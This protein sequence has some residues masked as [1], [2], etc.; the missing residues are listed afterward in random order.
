MHP[1][2]YVYIHFKKD[3]L[4]PFYVGKGTKYRLHDKRQRNE[5]WNNIVNKHG[6]IASVYEYFEEEQ[7]AFNLEIKLI[8]DLKSKGF[9]LCNIDDGG[10]GAKEGNKNLLGHK[11]SEETKKKIGLAGLGRKHSEETKRKIAEANRRRVVTEETKLKIS[12]A[13]RKNNGETCI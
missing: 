13:K 10:R 5:W 1:K 6:F 8:A 4:E 12:N 11:H 9:N 2:H 7:E 3:S